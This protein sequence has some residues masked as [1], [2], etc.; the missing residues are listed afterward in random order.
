MKQLTAATLA[1]LA[2]DELVLRDYVW[3]GA[4]NRETGATAARG[5]WSDVGSTS[6][7]VIVP[8][9]G[10]QTRSYVGGVGLVSVSAVPRVVGLTA[11]PVTIEMAAT[12]EAVND[13]VR[14]WTVRRVPVEI[15]RGA[16]DPAKMRLVE[17]A[18]LRFYGTCDDAPI[19]TP[20]AGG[21]SSITLT[22]APHTQELLRASERMRSEEDQRRRN[23]TDG[24][25]KHV[26]KRRQLRWLND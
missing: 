18:L 26:N 21:N 6:A 25:F 19:I 11:Q 12:D 10:V 16:L 2:A 3:I 8:G 1:R 20:E 7:Q 14:A 4:R 23:P 5:W 15:H 9:G 13:I 22:I 17:P 24:F